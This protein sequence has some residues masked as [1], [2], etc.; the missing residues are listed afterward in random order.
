MSF[1]SN[2]KLDEVIFDAYHLIAVLNNAL[3]VPY[4]LRDL[5]I[6]YITIPVPQKPPIF[7]LLIYLGGHQMLFRI[8]NE[9]NEN[10]WRSWKNV[11]QVILRKNVQNCFLCFSRKW[12]FQMKTHIFCWKNIALEKITG[13]GLEKSCNQ[14]LPPGLLSGIYCHGLS[15]S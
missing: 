7:H 9:S 11:A 13:F 14:F 10:Y 1:P 12:Q 15:C 2:H 8:L 5:C 4:F 3:L 6:E